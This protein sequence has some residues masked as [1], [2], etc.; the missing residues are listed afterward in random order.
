M[1]GFTITD[2]V[3]LYMVISLF[4]MAK[5]YNMGVDGLTIDPTFKRWSERHGFKDKLAFIGTGVGFLL[6]STILGFLW[7][8]CCLMLIGKIFFG[9]LNDDDEE[10]DNENGSSGGLA[11]S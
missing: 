11:A 10:D 1:D 4:C 9:N 2:I 8:L 3:F 7:P 5:L 6:L